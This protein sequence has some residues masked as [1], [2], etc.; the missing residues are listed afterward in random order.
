LFAAL[1]VVLELFVVE[2]DLLACRE[3]KLGAAVNTRED[4]IGEFHGRLLSQGSPPKSAM[5]RTEL[6]GPGSP[7]SF[8]VNYKGPDRTKWSGMRTFPG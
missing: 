5:A 6:A 1:G 3:N 4:S 2:E 7:L 8:V